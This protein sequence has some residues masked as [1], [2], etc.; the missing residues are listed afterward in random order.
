ANP[1]KRPA[2]IQEIQD[3]LKDLSDEA[4]KYESSP[5]DPAHSRDKMKEILARREFSKVAGPSA[6][7]LLLSRIFGWLE[8]VLDKL[9]SVRS[10]NFPVA[11]AI[12]Y[13]L[14]AIAVAVLAIWIVRRF[15]RRS[16]MAPEREIIPFSPSAKGWRA[17]LAEARALAQQQEWRESVHLA[18]WAGISFLEE[19]GSWKPDRARTPREYLRLLNARATQYPALV[20]L[21]RK[22]EVIWYGHRDASQADFQ[23]ALGQLEKLGC[24]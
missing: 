22:F 13:L 4:A 12:I 15:G 6:K 8:R 10:P 17:W 16:D 14:I 9:F 21:T 7:D 19:H 11:Q 2:L 1:E 24:R 18:Y 5:E 20:A 23:E 3:H